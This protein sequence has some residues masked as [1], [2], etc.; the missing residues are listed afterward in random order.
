MRAAMLLIPEARKVEGYYAYVTSK[1]SNEL[2]VVDADP[3][4]DGNLSDAMI[5]GR[6]SLVSDSSTA[7]DDAI[8]GL[9]GYGGQGVL[10]IP[11]VYNSWVKNLPAEWKDQLTPAQ[12]TA[13][14]N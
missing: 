8:S 3:N 4:N 14:R 1:F 13:S 7:R 5:A 12:Q 10:A 6:I 11:N 9:A 2:I